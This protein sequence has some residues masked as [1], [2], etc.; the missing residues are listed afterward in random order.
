MEPSSFRRSQGSSAHIIGDTPLPLS[1]L[2]LALLVPLMWGVQYVIIKVGLTAFP[3]L[4]FVAL[5]F[6]IIAVLLIPFIRRPTASEIWPI[7]VISV[8]VG[9]LNFGLTFAGLAHGQA[10]VASIVNQLSSPFMVLLAWPLLG[11]RPSLRVMVGVVLAFGG[12]VVIM[13]TPD[14]S[15]AL[16]P[17]LLIVG[18]AFALAVGSDLTKRYGPFEPLM[19]MG[20]MSLFTVPQ[21]LAA[22]LLIE[23]GQFALLHAASIGAWLALAYTVVF[24]GVIA[25]CVWFWLIGHYS[26]SRVAPFALLQIVFA[27]SAGVVFL[28]E[29]ITWRIVVGTVICIAGVLITQPKS[30]QKTDVHLPS[31]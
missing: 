31:P 2:C 20:W 5:R 23:H 4:F 11:E 10:G 14:A 15:I 3:P 8:F 9:G 17:T 26:M 21:V 28:H 6:F 13:A 30:V 16:V 27:V 18:A 12:V 1:R 22:S 29:P 7:I 24:G 25:F 19:L